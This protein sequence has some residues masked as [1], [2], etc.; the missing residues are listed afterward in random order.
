M[1]DPLKRAELAADRRRG[2][3][4]QVAFVA[5]WSRSPPARYRWPDLAGGIRACAVAP[6]TLSDCAVAL[7]VVRGAGGVEIA[8]DYPFLRSPLGTEKA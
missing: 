2:F 4:E 8:H 3:C 6:L 1:R 7:L 5:T